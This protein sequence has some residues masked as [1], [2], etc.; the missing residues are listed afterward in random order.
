MSILDIIEIGDVLL[1]W[2]FYV[3][4]AITGIV[5]WLAIAFIPN[6]TAAWAIAIPAGVVGFV[7]SFRWQH[8]ADFG[9]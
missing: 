6:E 4:L 3:G 7:L 8:Q 1:S 5:C 9:K 2:R